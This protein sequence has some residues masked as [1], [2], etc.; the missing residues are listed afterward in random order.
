MIIENFDLVVTSQEVYL[1]HQARWGWSGSGVCFSTDIH[2]TLEHR[3]LMVARRKGLLSDAP[4]LAFPLFCRWTGWLSLPQRIWEK[5]PSMKRRVERGDTVPLRIV[6]TGKKAHV[7]ICLT[8][9]LTNRSSRFK[10]CLLSRNWE[11]Y[12]LWP[13]GP[14]YVLQMRQCL[15]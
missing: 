14:L 4:E 1:L 7:F 10:G 3:D 15:W 5:W 6:I 12:L 2:R 11:D 9:V 13:L 8:F